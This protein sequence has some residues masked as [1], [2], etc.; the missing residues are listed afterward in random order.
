MD[1]L[2]SQFGR[3]RKRSRQCYI[4]FVRAGVELSP[5]WENL[6]KQIL[7][8]GEAFVEKH[9]QKINAMAALDDIP[10]F[11]KRGLFVGRVYDEANR[12]IL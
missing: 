1:W 11:Q 4:D 9:Q 5:I 7:L 2:L 10:A 12:R 8:G 6:Q 3:Q